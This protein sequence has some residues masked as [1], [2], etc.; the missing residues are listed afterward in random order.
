MHLLLFLNESVGRLFRNVNK[1]N[2]VIYYIFKVMY[3]GNY[4][5]LLTNSLFLLRLYIIEWN[6][7]MM[8]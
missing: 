5:C 7:Y 4:S 6:I 3:K 8:D 2:N 1:E